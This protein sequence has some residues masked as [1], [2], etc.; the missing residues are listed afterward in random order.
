MLGGVPDEEVAGPR[1]Y[2]GP[3]TAAGA[4]QELGLVW[5]LS[6]RQSCCASSHPSGDS[7][8]NLD[9]RGQASLVPRGLTYPQ[10]LPKTGQSQ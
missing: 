5:V 4:G 8:G 7:P 3:A 2:M 6:Q 1:G 9:H 10:L